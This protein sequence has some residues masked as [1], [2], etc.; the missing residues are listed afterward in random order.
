MTVLGFGMV[1]CKNVFAGNHYLLSLFSRMQRAKRKL[2]RNGK[3]LYT[4]WL[5]VG[6][7]A[8]KHSFL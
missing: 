6:V 4:W 8:T 3:F 7:L 1:P 2:A 5:R